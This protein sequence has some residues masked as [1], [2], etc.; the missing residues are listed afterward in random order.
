MTQHIWACFDTAPQKQG[1]ILCI[2]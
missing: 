1:I 2:S